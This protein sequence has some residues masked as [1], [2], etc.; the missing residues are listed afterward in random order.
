MNLK[1]KT[2]N[3][4]NQKRDQVSLDIGGSLGSIK[5]G[6]YEKHF[7]LVLEK[8]GYKIV[9]VKTYKKLKD[10]TN[11]VVHKYRTM[12]DEF[13]EVDFYIPSKKVGFWVTNLGQISRFREKENPSKN[14]NEFKDLK[15]NCPHCTNGVLPTNNN[16]VLLNW[17]CSNCG[18][19]VNPFDLINKKSLTNQGIEEYEN[20]SASTQAHK[21][22][23]YRI[24]ELIEAKTSNDDMKC[25]EIIYNKRK[26]WRNWHN[27]IDI[28]FDETLFVFDDLTSMIG[29]S[30]FENQ[31]KEKIISIIKTPYKEKDMLIPVIS[32]A[33]K[34]RID[35]NKKYGK[36][37]E[38]TSKSRLNFWTKNEPIS[39]PIRYSIY[40]ILKTQKIIE[41]INPYEYGI[42]IKIKKKKFIKNAI[43]SKE[44]NLIPRLIKEDFVDKDLVNLT[45]KGESYL[46]LCEK[47]YNLLI[48]N[49]KDNKIP[50]H[51]EKDF[52]YNKHK[53]R[54]VE[55]LEDLYSQSLKNGWYKFVMIAKNDYDELSETPFINEQFEPLETLT[56]T[57]LRDFKKQKIVSEI[58]GE[59]GVDLYE[60]TW[61]NEM[62]F[63]NKSDFFLGTDASIKLPNGKEIFIQ[64]KSNTAF[65]KWKLNT[66]EIKNSGIPYKDSKRM[67]AHNFISA[68][69]IKEGTLKFNED[70]IYIGILDGNW[71]ANKKDIYRTI[72][73]MYLLGVD[74]V[75]FAD[76][77]ETRIKDYLISKGKE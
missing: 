24:G 48:Q 11:I 71:C 39:F 16:E 28:F 4:T 55:V 40:G 65:K 18:C 22:A 46:K 68:F 35:K 64:C 57:Y 53:D 63:A 34:I 54:I 5:G 74:E 31:F 14:F 70:R 43:N 66:K 7:G 49:I 76:E 17:T 25:V 29:S 75:F 45:S 44:I 42:L 8:L 52:W 72:K 23:Y 9:D 32:T 59:A 67:I 47:Y 50:Y 33:K 19:Q 12:P 58:D 77:F 56:Y 30:T 61:L 73:L 60:K 1:E 69:K 3:K 41:G 51:N 6:F 62:P 36:W 10:L 38:T 27:V 26:D 13:T 20:K 37:L 15:G 21:Q 2:I